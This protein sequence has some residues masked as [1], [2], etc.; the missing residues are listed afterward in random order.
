M[1]KSIAAV[2]L[3]VATVAFASEGVVKR[4]AAISADAKSISLA[5]VLENPDQYT[6]TPVVVDGTIT[7]A[8]TRMG[9]FTVAPR[10]FRSE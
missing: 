6:K 9:C 4:G 2:A 3:L 1:K 10:C 5:K 8:C 7:M